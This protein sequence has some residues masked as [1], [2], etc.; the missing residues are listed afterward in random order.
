MF[1]GVSTVPLHHELSV[2]V[3]CARTSPLTLLWNSLFS[4][5]AYGVYCILVLYVTIQR[6]Y[7][8]DVWLTLLW[9]SFSSSPVTAFMVALMLTSVRSVSGLASNADS[10]WVAFDASV[11]RMI[12]DLRS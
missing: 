8:K 7:G 1:A 4:A 5:L 3:A 2:R 11:K 10:A 12:P 6:E 9:N